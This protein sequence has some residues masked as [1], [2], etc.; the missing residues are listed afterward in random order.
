MT[1]KILITDDERSIREGLDKV[2]R[3]EG[4]DVD[5]A[6]NGQVAIEKISHKHIDLLLLDVGLPFKDG[7]TTMEWLSQFNPLL[8]VIII[9][10]RW[11][12]TERAETS[13]ADLLM[14]KPLD[15]AR[16]LQNIRQLL[17]EPIE[18][19]AKRINEHKRGFQS[20]ACDLRQFRSNLENRFTTPFKWFGFK[21]KHS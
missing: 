1:A 7:W 13:G 10:G 4:Y 21:L 6:E 19:R 18:I 11:K 16:L 14:E 15:V 9:T 2:L 12:Q 20:V 8:P 17:A 5:L 3:K